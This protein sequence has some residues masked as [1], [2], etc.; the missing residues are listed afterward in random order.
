[1]KRGKANQFILA[2]LFLTFGVSEANPLNMIDLTV[3]QSHVLNEGQQAGETSLSRV[4]VSNP[5]VVAVHSSDQDLLIFALQPGT[6]QITLWYENQPRQQ[7]HVNVYSEQRYMLNQFLDLFLQHA[8]IQRHSTPER[9]WLSGQATRVEAAQLSSLAAS[10]EELD[11]SQLEQLAAD[12][13][14]IEMEVHVV[15][16]NRRFLKQ[17]GLSWNP[18]A[19]GPSFGLLSD[20][21]GGRRFRLFHDTSDAWQPSVN[22]LGAQSWQGLYAYLG[23]HTQLSSTLRLLEERG[24]ARILA[25]PKLRLESGA[26]AEFLAGGELPLPQ[27]NKDGAM[28]VTFHPYGIKINTTA[29]R[30]NN[31]FI[32]TEIEAEL[33]RIDHAVAIQGVPGLLTRRSRSEVVL[34]PRETIVLSGLKSSEDQQQRSG[35]PGHRGLWQGLMQLGSAYESARKETEL[36]VFLTPRLVADEEAQEQE[37][38]ARTEGYRR[39][40]MRAGCRGLKDMGN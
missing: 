22:E 40:L 27:L 37:R 34:P 26:S 39:H 3:K 24:E 18:S 20:W 19:Q 23:L 29:V 15:E 33:S 1:M 38:Q 2:L 7:F 13:Q 4:S 9:V 31:G 25:T 8:R 16:F 11:V 10:F 32:R 28:D 6:S 35:L 36:L 12:P 5:E 30:L 17:Q 14:M 21:L